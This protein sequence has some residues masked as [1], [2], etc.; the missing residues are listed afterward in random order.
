MPDIGKFKGEGPTI[1]PD[2]DDLTATLWLPGDN[3]MPTSYKGE[4]CIVFE[5]GPDA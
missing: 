3:P 2:M 5:L 4:S 1:T